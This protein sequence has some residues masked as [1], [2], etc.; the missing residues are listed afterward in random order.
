LVT[1]VL[2]DLAW[3]TIRVSRL[4][5]RVDLLF[6]GLGCGDL[7][8]DSG[9]GAALVANVRIV[10][11]AFGATAVQIVWFSRR[12]SRAVEHL[13]ADD[14]GHCPARLGGRELSYPAAMM[15]LCP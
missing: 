8:T 11:T 9:A 13:F 6:F 10:K 2:F 3:L 15:S 7:R 4:L 5:R 14:D 1:Q 12:G